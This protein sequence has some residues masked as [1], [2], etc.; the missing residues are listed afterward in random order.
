MKDGFNVVCSSHWVTATLLNCYTYSDNDT[1]GYANADKART[2]VIFAATTGNIDTA[3]L[4][5]EHGA[6][7]NCK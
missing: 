4:L 1:D 5:L 2:S 7:V 6:D 3:E